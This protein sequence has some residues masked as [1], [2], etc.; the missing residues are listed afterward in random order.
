MRGGYFTEAMAWRDWLL[1]AVAGRRLQAPDHVRAGG[2]ASAGRVGGRLA[3]R[4][5]GLGTGPHR[6]RGLGAVPARRLRRGHVGAVLLGHA[7]RACTAGPRGASRPSWSSSS[8]R[9]GTEPDDGIWEVR[10]PRRH[11]T[12]SK[13]M[14]WVAVDRAVRTLEEWPDLKGPL[15]RVA[16]A[17]PRHLH[18][19]LREGLQPGRRRLH[20]VLR[21]RRARCQRPHDPPGRL[22]PAERSPGGEHRRGGAARAHGPRLRAALPD[23]RRR[24]GRRA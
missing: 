1:R 13:V 8:R 21:L 14:A 5:R 23:G 22:P 24:R 20:P 10:G 9:D 3:A 15:E 17:A 6:Q 16:D 18:R 7:P 4:L 12:H 19:G 11:F 2:R